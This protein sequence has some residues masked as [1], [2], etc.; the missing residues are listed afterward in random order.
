MNQNYNNNQNKAVKGIKYYRKLINADMI[1][2]LVL[3][4]I[5]MIFGVIA[6]SNDGV[7]LFVRC[8]VYIIPVVIILVNW[9]QKERFV[10]NLSIVM[11]L[12]MIL[13]GIFNLSL[14]DIAF[15][16]LGIFNIIHSV[17]YL[18]AFKKDMVL[19][20]EHKE[21]KKTRFVWYNIGLLILS[22]VLMVVGPILSNDGDPIDTVFLGIELLLNIF[23]FGICIYFFIKKYKLTLL[24]IE[25]IISILTCLFF[26]ILFIKSLR[27][28]ISIYNYN[29]SDEYKQSVVN[30]LQY[31][32]ESTTSYFLKY[33]IL[34]SPSAIDDSKFIIT[35][36]DLEEAIK[37]YNDTH[38]IDG[39]DYK[40]PFDNKKLK[41]YDC[42]GYIE[43]KRDLTKY[44][45]CI[46]SHK[47]SDE[48]LDNE[49][50]KVCEE[51][52]LNDYVTKAYIKC[53]GK[54]KYQTEGFDTS[55]SQ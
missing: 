13:F 49:I 18:D 54:Y 7:A 24:Y 14:F 46:S 41:G 12:A 19:V 4:L 35:R 16:I 47:T 6:N 10:G 30:E 40:S 51:S 29:N 45:D 15:I 34:S 36:K 44:N 22:F 52:Y 25:F 27:Y 5:A 26:G 50:V 9:K 33:E 20:N 8:F 11:S 28:D 42:T 21:N 43:S 48:D 37:K 1:V 17:L 38:K 3:S 23:V 53:T 32:L 39:D 55:N 31:E 2:F